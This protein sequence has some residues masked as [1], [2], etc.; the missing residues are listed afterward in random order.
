MNEVTSPIVLIVEDEALLMM[1]AET[2]LQEAGFDVVAVNDGES[3]LSELERGSGFLGVVTDINLGSGP[4]GWDVAR[5]AREL[6]P[7]IPVVYVSGESGAQWAS[8]GVPNSVMLTKP[9]AQ[10]QLI[11]A[12]STLMNAAPQIDPPAT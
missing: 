8:Q 4:T 7:Q 10:V 2:A 3:A 9:F 5:R 6:S 12:L 1:E 11:T